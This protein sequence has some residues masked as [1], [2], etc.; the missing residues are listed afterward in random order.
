MLSFGPVKD[1]KATSHKLKNGVDINNA[2]LLQHSN[3]ILTSI[4]CSKASTGISP[5]EILSY[6]TTINVTNLIK[7]EAITKYN[8]LTNQ[9]TVLPLGSEHNNKMYYE[10]QYFINIINIINSETI[11]K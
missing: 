2:V 4:V 11:W 7:L 5:S 9:T 8:S 10:L 6:D 1:V 3:N